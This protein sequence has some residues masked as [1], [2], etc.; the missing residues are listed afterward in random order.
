MAIVYQHRRKDTNEIFYIGIGK[1]ENRAYKC[2]KFR[3]EFWNNIAKHGY[4]IEITHRDITWEEACVIEKYL[5]SFYGRRD[6]DLGPLVNLTDG[7]EGGFGMI[8][9]DEA[10]EKIRQFQLSLNKKGKPGRKKSIEEIEKIRKKLTGRLHSEE[11]KIAMMKPR[12]NKEN[13]KK[14]KQKIEC[15]HCGMQSQPATAYRFHFDNCLAITGNK[16]HE[17]KKYGKQE[18][19]TCPHCNK[20]GGRTMVR[21]HFDN[22]KNKK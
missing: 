15:P 12:L 17:G 5:I 10:R 3:S 2:G 7:G 14:P 16:K 18:T 1:N 9:N 11:T 21:W 19:Y 8:L 13:Y 20:Q 22:C 6:L 4:V